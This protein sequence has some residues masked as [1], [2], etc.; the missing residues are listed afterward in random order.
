MLRATGTARSGCELPSGLR[1]VSTPGP[2]PV[3]A[4]LP[5]GFLQGEERVGLRTE[6]DASPFIVPHHPAI[7]P[8]DPARERLCRRVPPEAAFATGHPR[9]PS[10]LGRSGSASRPSSSWTANGSRLFRV[11][12]GPPA[13]TGPPVKQQPELGHGVAGARIGH[14]GQVVR[15]VLE[16]VQAKPWPLVGRLHHGTRAIDGHTP[17][18]GRYSKRLLTVSKIRSATERVRWIASDSP[19]NMSGFRMSHAAGV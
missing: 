16:V 14:G 3:L 2:Y 12:P 17:R 5:R 11:I 13:A 10:G 4:S 1:G 15:P 9:R 18:A 7:G 19:V 6:Q 8:Q